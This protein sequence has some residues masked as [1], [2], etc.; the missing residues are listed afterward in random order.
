MLAL[1]SRSFNNIQGFFCKF[2]EM[3]EY[4]EEDEERVKK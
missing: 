4:D 2:S 1:F 3:K